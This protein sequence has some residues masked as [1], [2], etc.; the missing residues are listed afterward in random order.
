MLAQI[1]IERVTAQNLPRVLTATGKV[2]FNEDQTARILAPL[3]GQALDL[4][5]RVGDRVAKDQVLF[6]IKSREVAAMVTDCLQGQ[7]DQDLAEKTYNMTKDLFEHQAASQD[8]A[9]AGRRRI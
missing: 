6:S 3:A 1:K 7:R 4:N 8:R 2:Q 9:A 5:A